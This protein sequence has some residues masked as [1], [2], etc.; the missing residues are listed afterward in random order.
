MAI[1][2]AGIAEMKAKMAAMRSGVAGP[3]SKRAVRA[4]GRVIAVAMIEAAPLNDLRNAS[5]NSLPAGAFKEDI[6]VRFPADQNQTAEAVALIGPGKKTSH[7]QR[8]VEYGHRMVHGG[9][10]KVGADGKVRGSGVVHD[11]DV[12]AHPF[13]RPA[14]EASIGAAQEA[15]AANMAKGLKEGVS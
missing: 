4:G 1:E 9:Q 3:I 8:W 12:P 6:K 15:I 5:S 2:T 7:V 13:L 10:S 14:F 11:V